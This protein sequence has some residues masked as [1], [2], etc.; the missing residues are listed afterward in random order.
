MHKT[1]SS[2]IQR[3]LSKALGTGNFVYADMGNDRDL[4]IGP[5]HSVPIYLLFSSK[6]NRHDIYKKLR[7]D[8]QEI[9]RT[10]NAI[11]SK[12]ERCINNS[13]GKTVIISGEGIPMLSKSDLLNMKKYFERYFDDILIV[14]YIRPPVSYMESTFQQIIQVFGFGNL[15][16]DDACSKSY[17]KYRVRFEKFY[18]IFSAGKVRLWK[19]NPSVFPDKCVV[20]D[21]CSR[22]GIEVPPEMAVRINESLSKEAVSLLYFYKKYRTVFETGRNA[23]KANTRLIARVSE[24][25]GEK[26]SFSRELVD[27]ILEKNRA[28]IEWMEEKLGQTLAEEVP[29]G[30]EGRITCEDDL[31]RMDVTKTTQLLD[32]LYKR[33]VSPEMVALVI[34]K[35]MDI[36][37]EGPETFDRQDGKIIARLVNFLYESIKT[38]ISVGNRPGG[39]KKG[40]TRNTGLSNTARTNKLQIEK[41]DDMLN[42]NELTKKLIGRISE[43]FDNP[44]VKKSAQTVVNQFVQLLIDELKTSGEVRIPK[45]GAFRVIKKPADAEK[46]ARK[47]I[48]F[49]MSKDLREYFQ[50]G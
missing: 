27:P 11:R 30:R 15:N 44:A 22:L 6:P 48:K 13:R 47:V 28:D 8:K 49:A 17:P 46:P 32:L 35:T 41:K 7:W 43:K 19:F 33:G 29:D 2:S 37:Q 1:G 42:R 45:L 25:K 16:F 40:K 9:V 10:R 12:L 21:F 4:P 5:N 18:D 36:E 34:G 20:Q 31:L 14:G 23:V 50:H 24:I 26:I 38:E 39:H 3:T